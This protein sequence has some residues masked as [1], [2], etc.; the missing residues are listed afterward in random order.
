MGDEHDLGV[1]AVRLEAGGH[2][3]RAPLLVA[4]AALETLTAAPA[5]VHDDRI[6]GLQ[7]SAPEG[8][9][10]VGTHVVDP[11]R[12]LVAQRARQIDPRLHA[13]DDVQVR[14]AHARSRDADADLRAGRLGQR[15][16]L[17]TQRLA[18]GVEANGAHRSASGS[19]GR[20]SV[21]GRGGNRLR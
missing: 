12:D 7:P 5:A 1:A 14:V 6:A 19:A 16:V 2:R 4:V 15:H 21:A 8:R 3:V 11:T 9:A 10:R 18:G 17:D 20:G 13:V